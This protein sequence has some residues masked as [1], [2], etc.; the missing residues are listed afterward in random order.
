MKI[1]IFLIISSFFVISCI[2]D[3]KTTWD[4]EV[5]A[6]I[7]KSKLT[8]Q[9]LLKSDIGDTLPD[10]SLQLVYSSDLFSMNTDSFVKLPD[11]A[12]EIGASLKTLELP[13]YTIN[14]TITFGQVLRNINDEN[15]TNLVN[16]AYA[17]A[18]ING[19]N[20]IIPFGDG[21]TRTFSAGGENFEI[22]MGDLF[23]EIIL[24]TGTVEITLGNNTKYNLTNIVFQLENAPLNS[25]SAIG[26]TTFDSLPAGSTIS[27]TISLSNK[28]I[29]SELIGLIQ[30]LELNVVLQAGQVI[31][32]NEFINASIVVKDIKAKEATAIWPDQNV[33]DEISIVPFGNDLNIELK[34][35]TIREGSIYFEIYSSLVDSIYLTFEVLNV[36]KP[37]TGISFKIDTVI[38]PADPGGISSMSNTYSINGYH[39][40][41]NGEGYLTPGDSINALLDDSTNAYVTHLTARIQNTGLKKT[42]SLDDTVFVKAQVK[43][44]KPSFARGYLGNQIFKAGPSSLQFDLFNKIKSGQINLED[45]DFEIE[46]DNGIGASAEARFSKISGINNNNNRV[47]LTFTAG[48]EVMQINSASYNGEN[49]RTT[50]NTSSK[51]LTKSNSN[52]N[53]FIENFPNILEYELEVELNH[54]EIKPLLSD[55]LNPNDPP[56][57]IHHEDDI[58]ARLIMEVPLSIIADSLVLVDTLDFNLIDERGEDVESGKFKLIVDNGFPLD[59]NTSIYFMDEMGLIIDSLWSRETILRADVNETGRVSSKKRT[60]INFNISKEKMDIIKVASK[61]YIVAGFHSYNLTSSEKTFYRIYN[62]YSFGVK[63]VGDFKYQ[64]SN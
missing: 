9:D 33:I 51:T 16:S 45:V 37:S 3:K 34:D 44:L 12:F 63:L 8:V 25:E 13:T 41:F 5:L 17:A 60:V 27:N 47:D 7:V 42:I 21:S 23:D 15:L 32:T 36:V 18:A 29:R 30:S 24:D 26:T 19:T 55:I 49:N 62:N 35:A 43:E 53:K 14:D 4:T 56:N 22:S 39:F 2:K 58:K 40:D 64:L 11:S 52:I 10:G 59:A 50:H 46:V 20:P 31:D 61:V 1:P 48:D 6:P 28:N 54:G 38:P 57:F